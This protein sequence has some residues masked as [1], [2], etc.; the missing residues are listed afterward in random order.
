MHKSCRS[1]I[2]VVVSWV[3][4]NWWPGTVKGTWRGLSGGRKWKVDWCNY[5]IF[6]N[7]NKEQDILFSFSGQ[8][9]RKHLIQYCEHTEDRRKIYKTDCFVLWLLLKSNQQKETSWK[10]DSYTLRLKKITEPIGNK[11]IICL[12]IYA[13]R[14]YP[15]RFCQIQPH[16]V[17]V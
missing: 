17:Y 13:I 11:G 16:S 14:N 15:P 6:Q 9:L 5:I 3:S 10:H 12:N 1:W 8:Y 7:N 2:W 4:A